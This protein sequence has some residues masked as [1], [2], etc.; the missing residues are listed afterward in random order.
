MKH[1]V[2]FVSTSVLQDLALGVVLIPLW[3]V[4]GIRLFIFHVLA[5]LVFIKTILRGRA[6]RGKPSLPVE[7]YLLLT[8][9]LVYGLSFLLNA[10]NM[11]TVRALASLNN[12]SFWLMGFCVIFA[13]SH[14]FPREDGLRLLR[15][16]RTFG[17]VCGLFVIFSL[18]SWILGY[19]YWKAKSLLLMLAPEKTVTAVQSSGATLLQASLYLRFVKKDKLFGREFPRVNGFDIYPNS[20][21]VT[22]ILL[23]MMTLAH[24]RILKRKRKGTAAVLALEGLAFLLSLSRIA[25]LALPVAALIVFLTR[26]RAL[27]LKMIGGVTA[28][29]VIVLI[30]ISPQKLVRAASDFRKGST[31]SRTEIY[32]FTLSEVLKKPVLGHGFKPRPEDVPIPVGSHSTYIGVLYRTGFLG[33]IVFGAFWLAVLRRWWRQRPRLAFDETLRHVWTFGGVALLSGLIWMIAEDL[34]AQ[35]VVSFLFFIVVGVI[36]SLERIGKTAGDPE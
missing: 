36:L 25:M 22:M 28:A 27:H 14:A 17:L 19:K 26:G 2:P 33:W 4:L 13:V 15:A 9:I 29:L 16:F 10:K 11:P 20:L 23:L 35:P 30:L 12:L 1:P 34:D 8:F 7:N 31:V 32:R 3:Y 24:D 5:L 21:G 18:S 6:G